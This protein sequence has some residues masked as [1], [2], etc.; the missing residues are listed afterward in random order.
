MEEQYL[1]KEEEARDTIW[2][3]FFPAE[4]R[5]NP[6]SN[7]FSLSSLL[8]ILKWLTAPRMF[9]QETGWKARWKVRY[10]C[11]LL[12]WLSVVSQ[13]WVRV[14]AGP[15]VTA[16]LSA[17]TFWKKWVQKFNCRV[18]KQLCLAKTFSH[19]LLK[20]R[21]GLQRHKWNDQKKSYCSR[22]TDNASLVLL[23]PA[24]SDCADFSQIRKDSQNCTR[25]GGR[26][27]SGIPSGE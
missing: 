21:S 7:L 15:G 6:I 8:L 20:D 19:R 4:S 10:A 12:I 22:S 25:E 2:G 3:F 23:L 18:L 14:T 17:S 27:D 16:R 5:K 13:L 26:Y 9:K 24:P 11:C 1:G